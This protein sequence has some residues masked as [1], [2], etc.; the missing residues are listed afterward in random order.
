MYTAKELSEFF[1]VDPVTG[2]LMVKV[3]VNSTPIGGEITSSLVKG[4][5]KNVGVNGV[6]I[7]MHRIVWMITNGDIP[8]GWVVDHINGKPED[9]RPDNLRA[10]SSADNLL[11]RRTHENNKCGVKGVYFDG[12]RPQARKWR[13]QIRMRGKKICLGRFDTMEQAQA[14]YIEASQKIHGEFS[15]FLSEDAR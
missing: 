6:V 5:Y 8:D 9:N 1:S 15:R 13:A 14:A 4:R 7:P 2:Y 12:S 11:N 3:K 10:C